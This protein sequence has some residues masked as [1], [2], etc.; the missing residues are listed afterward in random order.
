[1]AATPTSYEARYAMNFSLTIFALPVVQ[2][3]PVQP[4]L[5]VH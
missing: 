4:L 3:C 1:M 2:F 5:Q